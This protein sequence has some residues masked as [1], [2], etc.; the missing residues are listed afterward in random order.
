MIRPAR[1][2]SW[3]SLSNRNVRSMPHFHHIF[4]RTHSYALVMTRIVSIVSTCFL[5]IAI[6]IGLAVSGN[7]QMYNGVGAFLVLALMILELARKT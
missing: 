6:E 1:R 2:C 3:I 7:G 4:A 5:L